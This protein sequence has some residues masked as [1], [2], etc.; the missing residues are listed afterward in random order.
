MNPTRKRWLLTLAGLALLA[1]VLSLFRDEPQRPPPPEPIARPARPPAERPSFRPAPSDPTAPA[2]T[3]P[4]PLVEGSEP[5]NDRMMATRR[6]LLEKLKYA[7]GAVPLAGKTDLIPPHF[8]PPAER[9][10]QDHK[11]PS[12]RGTPDDQPGDVRIT[13]RQSTLFIVPG[14]QAIA[15]FQA[16]LLDGTHPPLTI[17]RAELIHEAPSNPSDPKA[18]LPPPMPIQFHDDGV[19]PDEIAG[20]GSYAALVP[21]APEVVRGFGGELVVSVD[22]M[23]AGEA[24]TLM[25]R[26]AQTGSAP[27]QLTL[28]AR[29]TVE[30]GSLAIYLGIAVYRP[31]RFE[32]RGRLYDSRNTPVALVSFIDELPADA[33]EVR[34]LTYGKLLRD[35]RAVPPFT[36][37]DIEGWRYALGEYPDREMMAMWA[38][39]YQTA[40]YSID[41]F[42]DQVWDSPDKRAKIESFD[43]AVRETT[44]AKTPRR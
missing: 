23:V 34:L 6:G 35:Q 40:A 8:V 7:P 11:D 10:L 3:P 22:V 24:G 13:Q 14:E 37:R 5:W 9:P 16:I 1:L 38:A 12:K 27:A 17:G 33:H 25:F 18:P 41:R 43:N 28:T 39:G 2:A 44:Q 29:D 15:S 36:L 26:F 32:I 31:G 20:D 19:P 42:T 4:A 30:D 21:P